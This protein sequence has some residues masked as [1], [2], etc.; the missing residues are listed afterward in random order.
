LDWVLGRRRADSVWP[1]LSLAIA[2]S[3]ASNWHND[4]LRGDGG[5]FWQCT[6]DRTTQPITYW[7]RVAV[8]ASRVSDYAPY[9]P[10]ASPPRSVHVDP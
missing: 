2:P 4:H 1:C 7:F 3:G 8:P 9:V 10:V 6:F 5:F